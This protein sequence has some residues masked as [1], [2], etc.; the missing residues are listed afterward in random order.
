MPHSDANGAKKF[1]MYAG[2]AL[3]AAAA[4][5]VWTMGRRL[6]GVALPFL[7]A[8]LLS[9]LVRPLVERLCGRGKLPRAPVAAGLVLLLVGGTVTLAWMGI[10]RGADELGRLAAALVADKDGILAAME[11]LSERLGSI[12]SHI[13]LL[14][15]FED[16]PGYAAFCTRLDDMVSTGIDR[17]AATV[18]ARLPDAA[19][20]VAEWVPEA[21]IFLTVTLLACY[22]FS[23]DDG[24]IG[25][26]FSAA[27][28]RVC[29]GRRSGSPP[30]GSPGGSPGEEPGNGP[31]NC[32]GFL[33][34]SL[35]ESIP[36][37]GRRLRRLGREYARAYLLLGLFTFLEVFIG[38]TILRIRYAFLLAWLI[39]LVDILPLLGTGVVLVPWGVIS[40]LLGQRR[41]GIG[42]LILFGLCTLL[43]QIA[44]PRLFGHG[45]GL[46]PLLT[47]MAT[48]AGLRLFG[49]VGMLVAPLVAAGVKTAVCGE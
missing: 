33:P 7:V 1:G 48:Y 19:M 6:W 39:A 29:R 30:S 46:H 2:I 45:L 16:A 18:G 11:L 3:V 27:L 17:L 12:S 9:R 34:E 14:R 28:D 26:G 5:V 25:R 4:A 32:P 49:V 23:A 35:R 21:L 8:Y 20:A 41:V 37:L 13:P 44:E 43:R 40:L 47:L 42:L 10:R 22:Y 24:R 15:H 36:A 31:G 38:L